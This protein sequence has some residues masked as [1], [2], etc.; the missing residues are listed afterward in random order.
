MRCG[1]C[2]KE[3]DSL[4]C[5]HCGYDKAEELAKFGGT[6]RGGGESDPETTQT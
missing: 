5:R 3:I 1:K 2:H 4:P 6:K